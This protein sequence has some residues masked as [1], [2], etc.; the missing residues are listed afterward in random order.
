M[1]CK[2]CSNL[3][4]YSIKEIKGFWYLI[5]DCHNCN[6]YVIVGEKRFSYNDALKDFNDFSS[7]G[8]CK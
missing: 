4:F 6:K 7:V 2:H 3:T 8:N 1:F 5:R